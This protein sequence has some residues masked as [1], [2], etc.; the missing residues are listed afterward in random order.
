MPEFEEEGTWQDMIIM[1]RILKWFVSV[2]C[3]FCDVRIERSSVPQGL[4]HYEVAGDDAECMKLVGAARGT[5]Y[6]NMRKLK[7]DNII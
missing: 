5:Y 6:K 1:P 3:K 2:E 4:Y 7:V